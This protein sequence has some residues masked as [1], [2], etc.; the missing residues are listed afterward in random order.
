MT[1]YKMNLYIIID[2]KKDLNQ[3]AQYFSSLVESGIID[4]TTADNMKT[5]IEQKH[6]AAIHT[7][8]TPNPIY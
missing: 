2:K 7:P 1:S 5:Y 6:P 4:Q 3:S 8:L